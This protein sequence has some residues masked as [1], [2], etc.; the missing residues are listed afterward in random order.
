MK[1]LLALLFVVVLGLSVTITFAAAPEKPKDKGKK[2]SVAMVPPALVSPYFIEAADAAKKAAA[3]QP[4]M[5]FVVLAPSDETK[6]DEQIKILED[7]IQKKVN[8]ILVS[9]G[10]WEAVAPVLKKAITGG[11]DVAIFNQLSDV[12]VLEKIGLVSAVGVDEVEG[13]KVAG[14]WVAKVLNGKGNVAVLEGVS[15][16]YWTVREG[17]GIDSALS[18]HKDIKIVARQPANWE[19][20]KGMEVTENILQANKQLDVICAMNDNMA[21]GAAQAVENAG[22]KKQ[23]KIIGYNGNEE[24][25]KAIVAGK[26]DATV[27]KQPSNV[28]RTLIEVIAVKVM[29]GERKDIKPIMRITP[30]IITSQNVNE[31]LKK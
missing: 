31:F 17:K 30:A 27:N 29:K 4:N 9:S 21:L 19:R 13:G 12:P 1:K 11:I 8:L 23:V 18:K 3:K 15:G 2:F 14:E 6:V 24:A 7:L 25:L 16:D 10:N 20:A 5:E 28:G 22:R 26:I